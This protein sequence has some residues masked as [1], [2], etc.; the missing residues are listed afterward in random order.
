MTTAL[1]NWRATAE[2]R[3]T[4]QAAARA[5]GMT[6]SALMREAALTYSAR[7]MGTR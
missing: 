6:M 1:M 3:G 5:M 7:A 4:V 2:Q